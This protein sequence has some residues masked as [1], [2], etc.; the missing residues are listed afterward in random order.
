MSKFTLAIKRNNNLRANDSGSYFSYIT[1]IFAVVYF[2]GFMLFFLLK[3]ISKLRIYDN[4][5][6][7]FDLSLQLALQRRRFEFFYRKHYVLIIITYK[8]QGL[9][10]V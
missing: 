8:L 10:W 3:V 9:E 6:S 1:R 4:I 7:E 2:I 5:P